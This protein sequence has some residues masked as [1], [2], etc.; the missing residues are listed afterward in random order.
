MLCS[1]L[2]TTSLVQPLGQAG[3]ELRT[4]RLYFLGDDDDDDLWRLWFTKLHDPEGRVYKPTLLAPV[5]PHYDVQKSFLR[6]SSRNLRAGMCL[7]AE[8]FL[9]GSTE[10]CMRVVCSL[11]STKH[12]QIFQWRTRHKIM[13]ARVMMLSTWISTPR[14]ADIWHSRNSWETMKTYLL[15]Q[16]SS[17]FTNRLLEGSR[18][19]RQHSGYILIVRDHKYATDRSYVRERIGFSSSSIDGGTFRSSCAC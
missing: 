7:A 13:E 6:L 4:S 10:L 5:L 19:K 1:M 17:S 18:K 9:K 15:L 11:P 3:Y 14:N 16:H 8:V 2:H 12:L